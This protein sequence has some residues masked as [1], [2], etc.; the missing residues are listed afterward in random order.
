MGLNSTLK[1]EVIVAKGCTSCSPS[2]AVKTHA[3]MVQ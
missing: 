2:R 3:Y 1:Q